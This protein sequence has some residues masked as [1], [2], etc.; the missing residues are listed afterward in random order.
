MPNAH[1]LRQACS[2]LVLFAADSIS[3]R[4][5]N[6]F[7]YTVYL[8]TQLAQ[9]MP[10]S[11]SA[12]GKRGESGDQ[13]A[14]RP[15]QRC[16]TRYP[17]P[18]SAHHHNQPA[19]RGAKRSTAGPRAGTRNAGRLLI[20]ARETIQQHTSLQQ[21]VANGFSMAFVHGPSATCHVHMVCAPT[22]T[23][24][25]RM[26]V[27]AHTHTAE[28][29]CMTSPTVCAGALETMSPVECWILPAGRL[30]TVL[31]RTTEYVRP[32]LIPS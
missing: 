18:A 25:T 5:L 8:K 23:L 30:E 17:S 11:K 29:Q 2:Q 26:P 3:T 10:R 16:A 12:W 27:R 24:S 32:P 1:F 22:S 9:R 7:A 13:P 19:V 21:N 14:E 15:A 6:V 20:C 31:P 4:R 28:H